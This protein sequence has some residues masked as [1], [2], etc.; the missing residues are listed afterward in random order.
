MRTALFFFFLRAPTETWPPPA[1][2]IIRAASSPVP[3]HR[4]R[5]SSP[6]ASPVGSPASI[7]SPAHSPAEPAVASRPRVLPP[8]PFALTSNVVQLC[9][10]LMAVHEAVQSALRDADVDFEYKPAK[11]KARCFVYRA[12]GACAFILRMYSTPASACSPAAS[13]AVAGESGPLLL[14]LQKR[15]GCAQVFARTCDRLIL[16]MYLRG[17]LAEGCPAAARVRGMH[18]DLAAAMRA[19]AVPAA[20]ANMTTTASAFPPPPMCPGA[21]AM[22]EAIREAARAAARAR[23]G[24]DG[25]VTA[26]EDDDDH[27]VEVDMELARRSAASPRAGGA[28]ATACDAQAVVTACVSLVGA[29]RSAYDDVCAPAAQSLALLASSPRVRDTLGASLAAYFAAQRAGV[30]TPLAAAVSVAAGAAAAAPA[31]AAAVDAAG[32]QALGL[33]R[34]LVQRA[35]DAPGT[36]L[37]CRTAAAVALAQLSRNC[38]VSEAL[39]RDAAPVALLDAAAAAVVGAE[40]AALRRQLVRAAL[41]VAPSAPGHSCMADFALRAHALARSPAHLGGDEKFAAVVRKLAARLP[42]PAAGVR[43]LSS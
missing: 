18:A 27:E 15:R 28:G 4:A 8:P 43:P 16:H 36:S 3:S 11:F 22:R 26:A 24:D 10:P 34:A 23:G 12:R 32:K 19:S 35:V 40:G 20:S 25:A 1:P 7:A 17:L 29:L 14:E 31:A 38:S 6:A 30:P 37:E 9:V 21:A 39:L 33:L 5:A 41:F 2:G 42:A 13:P